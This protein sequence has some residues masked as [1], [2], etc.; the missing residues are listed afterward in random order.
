[1]AVLALP[2]Y[3][4]NAPKHDPT[5]NVCGSACKRVRSP[6]PDASYPFIERAFSFRI[7]RPFQQRRSLS[8]GLLPD[9]NLLIAAGFI[10]AHCANHQRHHDAGHKQPN[11]PRLPSGITSSGN[12]SC[13]TRTRR[14]VRA[15]II[16]PPRPIATTGITHKSTVSGVNGGS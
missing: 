1:M 3:H 11:P 12:S 16:Q 2:K 7:Q 15:K 9:L 10:I 8:G 5:F 4:A 6:T 14:R 13:F